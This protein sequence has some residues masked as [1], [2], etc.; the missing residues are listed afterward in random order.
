MAQDHDM[1]KQPSQEFKGFHHCT[2]LSVTIN[3]VFLVIINSVQ[4]NLRLFMKH[5]IKTAVASRNLILQF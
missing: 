5:Q 1:K 3:V 4:F 2:D